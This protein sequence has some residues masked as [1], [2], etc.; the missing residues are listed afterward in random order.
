MFGAISHR[1]KLKALLAWASFI[2]VRGAYLFY[3]LLLSKRNTALAWAT[4]IRRLHSNFRGLDFL[5]GVLL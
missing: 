1:R 5:S 4:D 2:S 3:K